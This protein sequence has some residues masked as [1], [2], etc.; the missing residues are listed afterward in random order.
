MQ[1]EPAESSSVPS[2]ERAATDKAQDPPTGESSELITPPAPS[3]EEQPAIAPHHYA[4]KQDR[5]STRKVSTS[6]SADSVLATPAVRRMAR[7]QKV[8]LSAVKGSGREGRIM[9]EDLTAHSAAKRSSASQAS[10]SP[11]A[12]PV[13][14]TSKIPLSSTRRAMFK[15]MSNSLAIPHFALS[16][17]LDV[18]ALE[19][20]RLVLNANI[21]SKYQKTAKQPSSSTEQVAESSRFNRI[22]LLPLLVKALSCALHS[23]P[24]FLSSLSGNAAADAQLVQRSSHDISIALS[25]S[26][27]LYT[28]LIPSVESLN[29]FAIASHI[30]NLQHIAKAPGAPKF[31]PAMMK[32]GTITLSNVGV[33]G[34]TYTHPVIPPTGQLAIGALGQM[35][36]L[37]RYKAAHK[38]SAKAAAVS[39]QPDMLLELEPRLIMSVSFTADHRVVEGV[40]LARLVADWKKIVEQPELLAGF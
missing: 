30:A 4:P 12:P 25:S 21:P 6:S 34:G 29:P 26:E 39:G 18:T 38:Q 3:E 1:E 14:S 17:E 2:A 35:Q 7:E 8:D 28:P 36:V 27:G 10:S 24:L 23:H 32:P 13:A 20:M 9:K 22:T 16:E 37:P 11:S 40:E 33:V 5:S 19:R 15:A 31:T